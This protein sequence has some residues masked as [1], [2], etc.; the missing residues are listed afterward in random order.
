MYILKP[1][2]AGISHAPLF[3]TPPPLEGYFQGWGA[4]CIKFGPVKMTRDP[5]FKSFLSHFESPWGGIAG[6]TFE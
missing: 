3:Y 2:A 5:I 1:P 4:G 6:A